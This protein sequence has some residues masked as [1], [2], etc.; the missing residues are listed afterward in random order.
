MKVLTE[1]GRYNLETC[2]LFLDC[3]KA[4][5]R[6]IRDKLFDVLQSKNISN[7]LLKNVMEF[8]SG[9]KSKYKL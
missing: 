6:V 9:K 7:L 2:L 4:F 8:N 1:K 3:V 5:D